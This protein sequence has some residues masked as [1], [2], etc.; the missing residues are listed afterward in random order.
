MY[1]GGVDFW[2]VYG[3]KFE[4]IFSIYKRIEIIN[5]SNGPLERQFSFFKQFIHWKR[6]R[7]KPANLRESFC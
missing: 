1:E 2:V 6:N 7:I 4:K 5:I 3:R